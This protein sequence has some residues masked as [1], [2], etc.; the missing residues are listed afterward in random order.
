MPR[1]ARTLH[2]LSDMGKKRRKRS[3][4]PDAGPDGTGTPATEKRAPDD[5]DFD[6]GVPPDPDGRIAPD[7]QRDGREEGRTPDQ[8]I[9]EN[10]REQQSPVNPDPASDDHL[11]EN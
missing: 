5:T 1:V 11:R 9:V 6:R 7:H 10:A 3:A 8:A 4:P 2:F